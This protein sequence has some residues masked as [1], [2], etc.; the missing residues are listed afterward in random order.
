MVRGY[1][2]DV[3]AELRYQNEENVSLGAVF[4]FPLD[5]NAAVY[6][7]EGLVGGTRIEAQI[8]EQKQVKG[9]IHEQGHN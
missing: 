8:W 6:A 9:L 3:V 4:V 5:R 1:V 2:A 7:C